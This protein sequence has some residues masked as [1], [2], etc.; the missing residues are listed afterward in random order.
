[1]ALHV[2]AAWL[3]QAAYTGGATYPY[4]GQAGPVR[5]AQ[6]T[7]ETYK[8]LLMPDYNPAVRQEP[9]PEEVARMAKRLA[10]AMA[11]GMRPATYTDQR[12]L[13][14]AHLIN[15]GR[16]F[17]IKSAGRAAVVAGRQP[18]SIAAIRQESSGTTQPGN[19]ISYS[20]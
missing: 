3:P 6:A 14:A 9:Q 10:D 20:R 2:H 18:S 4:P 13:R 5:V 8:R 12:L 7:L 1:M 19:T 15:Q 17:V 11:A 16:P